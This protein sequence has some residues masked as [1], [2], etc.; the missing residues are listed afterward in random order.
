MTNLKKTKCNELAIALKKKFVLNKVLYLNCSIFNVFSSFRDNSDKEIVYFESSKEKRNVI[1]GDPLDEID[2]L[3]DKFDY[4]IGDLPLGMISEENKRE[5]TS[6]IFK[7]WQILYKSLNVLNKNGYGLFIIEENI[8]NKNVF[9]KQ[10]NNLGFYINAVFLCPK[11]IFYPET[12]I[13]V[14]MI[15][16]SRKKTENLFTVELSEDSI[17]SEILNRYDSQ[18]NNSDFSKG[19][20]MQFDK[21]RGVKKAKDFERITTLLEKYNLFKTY[22]LKE[23]S[24]SI[25]TRDNINSQKNSIYIPRVGKIVQNNIKNIKGNNYYQIILNQKKVYSDYLMLFFNTEVGQELL[26]LI[27]TGNYIPNKKLSDLEELRIPLPDLKIQEKIIESHK[28]LEQLKTKIDYFKQE[29]ALNPNNV[30]S[31]QE[32]L[33]NMLNSLDMLNESEKILSLIRQG[34]SKNLEFKSTLRKSIEKENV[35]YSVIEKATLKNLAGFMNSDGGILLVGVNDEGDLLGLENDDFK[36]NDD[37]LKHVKNIIKRDFGP[38][39][40]DLI[41]YKIVNVENKEVLYFE[42]K[43][44]NK[45]VFLGKEEEF[46]VR[47]NPAIDRLSGKKQYEYIKNHFGGI[48][49]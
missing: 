28:K 26:E 17:I 29:I 5:K 11:G 10:L 47:I 43:P 1:Y 46:Y 44:S 25:N 15:L 32:D 21:F 24:L 34:E 35:P 39:C 27:N 3:K 41:D 23:I 42:C 7:N 48:S 30:E 20:W 31:I 18:D 12:S 33:N 4:I 6:I 19:L 37:I 45:P 16:I 9:L 36:S 22:F 8:F 2:K 13:D 38:E 49:K 14:N 40:Y